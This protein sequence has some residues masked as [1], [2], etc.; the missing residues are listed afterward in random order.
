MNLVELRTGK[1]PDSADPIEGPLGFTLAGGRRL[2]LEN[3]GGMS[4]LAPR[5]FRRFSVPMQV[6]VRS[7]P[8]GL[9]ALLKRPPLI[10]GNTQKIHHQGPGM[11]QVRIRDRK[12]SG[13][14]ELLIE[15]AAAAGLN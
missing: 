2:S 4:Q 15:L 9:E 13:D 11:N 12:I 14:A 5:R 3:D 1:R 10:G 8:Q 6:G 7:L